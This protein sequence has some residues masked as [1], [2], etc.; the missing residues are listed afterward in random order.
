SIQAS[1]SVAS[2]AGG[3]RER[4][5]L[6][7]DWAKSLTTWEDALGKL[8]RACE[9]IGI[10]VFSNSVVGNNNH[11]PLDPEEF[12]GFVLV[13]RIAPSVFLNDADSKSAR[14]FTLAHELV[15]VWIGQDAIVN[16]VNFMP[17]SNETERFC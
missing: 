9:D 1:G 13:D 7:D 15:H 17:A 12:R 10:L 6:V 3:I 5:G 14:M 4:L 16:L 11:R 8:R 2:V